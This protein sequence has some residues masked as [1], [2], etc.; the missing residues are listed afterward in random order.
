MSDW[1]H[2]KSEFSERSRRVV[3]PTSDRGFPHYVKVGVQTVPGGQTA[4]VRGNGT[5]M[6]RQPN[7]SPK[8]TS[9]V[10]PCYD[11]A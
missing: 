11:E 2:R 8:G 6:T 10:R 3:V 5:E 4:P 1:S 9:F 7:R